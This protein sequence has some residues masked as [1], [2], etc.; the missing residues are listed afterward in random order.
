MTFLS[1]IISRS[2]REQQILDIGV[3]PSQAQIDEA[4][5]LLQGII[6]RAIVQTPQSIITLG[7]KPKTSKRD[8]LR[9]FTDLREHIAVPQNVYLHANLTTALTIFMPFNAGDGARL[10]IVDAGGNF[11][12]NP[13]TLDGNKGLVDAAATK[14]LSTNGQRADFFYR[15]DLAEWR[16]V[17]PLLTNS[18]MPFP[19]EFDDMFVLLLATRLLVRYGRAIDQGSFALL[20]EMRARFNARYQR[21]SSDVEADVLFESEYT[22]IDSSGGVLG[23]G[24]GHHGFNPGS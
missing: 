8:R 22:A 23:H 11:A 4:L 3:A 7:A 10:V 12:T 15:R 21:T 20:E 16:S 6:T 13:L 14:V 9:D 17:A 1:E 24:H 5:P 2:L 19:E 18:T